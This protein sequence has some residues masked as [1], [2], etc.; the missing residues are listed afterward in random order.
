MKTESLVK[1][2]EELGGIATAAQIKQA[3]YG[4]SLID[5]A[6]RRGFIDKLTRGVYCSIDVLDDGF[7]AVCSRWRKCVLSHGSA[8]YLLGLSDRAPFSLDV[9]VP[10]GYNPKSLKDENPGIRIHHVSPEL[11]GLGVIAAKTP[12]G[13]HARWYDAERSIADLIKER[14][15]GGVDA[16]L[17]HDAMG[18]YFRMEGR[19]VSRLA[20]VCEAMGVREELETY[21]EVL[22]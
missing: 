18:G 12:A 6:Y 9:T 13:N 19:D 4:A 3:G 5:H 17:V 15:R 2:I 1:Y 7:A 21:L 22:T 11:Y 14:R 16:Q 8:L 20:Q 10:H